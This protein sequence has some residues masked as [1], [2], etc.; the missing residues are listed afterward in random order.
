MNQTNPF[1]GEKSPEDYLF[2]ENLKRKIND[3]FLT[4]FKRRSERYLTRLLVLL[5]S[6]L[7]KNR[8]LTQKLKPKNIQRVLI[9]RWDL[10]GDMILTTPLFNFFKHINANIRI[11]I[12]ASEKNAMLLD[13]DTRISKIFVLKKKWSF[14]KTIVEIRQRQY[15]LVLSLTRTKSIADGLLAN[16]LAPSAVKASVKRKAKYRPFFNV[17]AKEKQGENHSVQRF[18]SA[19][20]A[21]VE[22]PEA[23]PILSLY[24]SNDVRKNA[25]DFIAK[26]NLKNFVA[27]NLSAG[28][29]NRAWGIDNYLLFLKKVLEVYPE[30]QI[31]LISVPQNI[32]EARQ[33]QENLSNKRLTILPPQPNIQLVAALIAES[34]LVFSPDTAII[35]L[36]SSVKK[37]VLGLYTIL[38]TTPQLWLPFKVP[39]RAVLAEGFK[40]VSTINVEDVFNAF[41]DL[42]QEVNPDYKI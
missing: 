26:H 37:P 28:N 4:R 5:L 1:F 9:L 22:H 8:P 41:K 32:I 33:I 21:A 11:E 29:S 36:A 6:H 17:F 34:N 31:L 2:E 14:L 15:D 18:F 24:I 35:H 20:L 30:L 12:V 23:S 7:L 10:L 3:S 40:P 27:V 39:Y 25:K 42:Y 13:G 19:V 38:G 16:I